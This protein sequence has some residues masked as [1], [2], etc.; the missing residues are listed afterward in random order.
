MKKFT[1]LLL[2]FV[3]VLGTASIAMAADEVTVTLNGTAVVF[4][5]AQP[6][7]DANGR[8]LV[9]LRPIADALEIEVD[10]DAAE[11]VATFTRTIEEDDVVIAESVIFT[12]GSDV[13]VHRVVT[14]VEDE[15]DEV[16]EN[17]IAMV[18]EAI[19]DNDRTLAPVRYLVEALGFEVDWDGATRTVLVFNEEADE[20]EDDEVEDEDNG[21]EDDDEDEDDDE[22][23]DDE[24]EDEEDDEDDEE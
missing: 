17:N 11:R 2:A 6:I 19:I 1:A 15:E 4:P 5:D 20:V 22:V 24:V 7:I 10:W 21:Y 14:T 13:A 8:T 16:E 23:A 9:P 18:T 3:M 12:I